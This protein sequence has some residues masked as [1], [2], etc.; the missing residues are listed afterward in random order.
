MYMK[1]IDF[2]EAYEK[3]FGNYRH[4]HTQMYISD[5]HIH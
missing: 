5:I 3:Y 4:T 1:D 2:M